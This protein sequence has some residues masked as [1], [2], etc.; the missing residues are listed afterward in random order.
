MQSLTS[1]QLLGDRSQDEGQYGQGQQVVAVGCKDG[2]VTFW[3][4]TT[5][6]AALE[7]PLER[8]RVV[9]IGSAAAG[10]G[11]PRSLAFSN[12]EVS[13]SDMGLQL[14]VGTLGNGLC[15]VNWKHGNV[16]VRK[17]T[18]LVDRGSSR[19]QV[20]ANVT[21]MRSSTAFDSFFIFRIPTD[22]IG[23]I[24]PGDRSEASWAS[25]RYC[26]TSY[27]A[28]LRDCCVG[29]KHPNVSQFVVS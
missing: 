6:K 5:G 3:H 16:D 15:A 1:L 2:S 14:L 10:L 21:N 13:G 23:T 29:P 17:F 26:C 9:G 25:P 27:G 19:P 24:F 8:R 12:P 18:C 4:V 28:N 7:A 20:T 11:P 22:P